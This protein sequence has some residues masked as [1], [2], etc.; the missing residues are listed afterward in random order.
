MAERRRPRADLDLSVQHFIIPGADP[1]E[2][3]LHVGSG[4]IVPALLLGGLF[5]SI[6]AACSSPAH[7]I[8]AEVSRGALVDR[9]TALIKRHKPEV[10]EEDIADVIRAGE[11][12]Q[13]LRWSR[14]IAHIKPHLRIAARKRGL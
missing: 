10:A 5:E 4:V 8:A 2:E 13:A 7:G 9:E 3:I 11:R 14:Q 12:R 6:P 1:I